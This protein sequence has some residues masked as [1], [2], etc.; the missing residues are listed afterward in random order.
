MAY[1]AALI[2]VKVGV[3]KEHDPVC[4]RC[5]PPSGFLHRTVPPIRPP[6]NWTDMAD[7]R[8]RQVIEALIEAVEREP[9]S[10][11][12]ALAQVTALRALERL[13]RAPGS[14]PPMPE[15]WH[16]DHGSPWEALD[17]GDSVDLRERWWR[18]LHRAGRL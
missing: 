6:T 9:T 15:D 16:P 13:T 17:A 5:G 14:I 1:H 10:G 8:K 18:S 2:A 4:R 12:A 3:G 7:D 11:R